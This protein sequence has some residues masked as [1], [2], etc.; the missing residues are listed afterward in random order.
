MATL[1]TLP[2]EI[3]S[4]IASHL[5]RPR[6]LLYLS[7]CC[8]R[9]FEF[10]KLDGW[11]AILKGRFGLGGLDLD[12]RRS[13]HG[14]STLYRNWERKG[15]VARYLE[16]SIAVTSINSW[17]PRR[18]KGPQGQTMGYQPSIDSYEDLYGAWTQRRE[19]LAWSAG[20]Q[21]VMRV[22]ETGSDIEKIR[23]AEEGMNHGPNQTW[24]YDSFR[25][26][27]SWFTYKIPDSFEGRD[28][29]TSLK[30]LR[31]HQRDLMNEDVVFGTASGRLSLL[32]MNP[33]RSETHEQTYATDGR[34]VGSLSISSS[35]SPLLAATLGDSSLALY[36]IDRE[37]P[38]DAAIE[39]FG[40]IVSLLPGART[41]RIW[42]SNFLAHDK[43]VLGAGPSPEPI[44]VY[45]IGPDGL[46]SHPLR[47]F[48]LDPN[49]WQD[50]K[51]DTSS[52]RSTSVYPTLPVP[53]TAKGGSDAGNTFL[54]GGY[55]G[56]IRLHDMRSPRGF[57]TLFWDAT[58]DSS[59]Y[60]LAAQ[61]LE[62]VVAG[63]SM[64]S[65]IK[66]FDLRFSGSNVYHTVARKPVR[67]SNTNGKDIAINKTVHEAKSNV[68]TVSGGW[69]LYLNPRIP[70][71]REAY[72]DDYWRGRDDSPVYRLS[73]PSPTSQNLYVGLEGAVQSLTFHSIADEHPDPMLSQSVVRFANSGHIDAQSSYNPCGDVLN[74]GM[75]EQGTEAGIGM[76]LFVQGG[77][78]TE[79][80]KNQARKDA[81]ESGGLD[82]RWKDLRDEGDRWVR[83]A[84]PQEP[85][86][87]R[88]RGRGGRG[89]ARGG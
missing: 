49:H 51:I 68:S 58:N 81:A 59:V 84:I 63:V 33:D 89:R 2:N 6:D 55:D 86:R 29:I 3:L 79:A 24:A 13:V 7:L 25:H 4:L 23:K 46:V 88:G 61:G 85:R 52:Q 19:V 32:S 47:S 67:G 71:K 18:W 76:Q 54:S 8:R 41:G 28:D 17:Q 74:L 26:L 12:A 45:K 34:A 42:S 44:Q 70:P 48:N 14:L 35:S 65:M 72:R 10:A 77:V 62:R 16:P 40:Q 1:S 30:L 56:I 69:N 31:P 5:E 39:P 20:T 73:I 75:Y 36:S 11:K 83:G 82:E 38:P 9:L 78:A 64:H 53:G 60:S 37:V 22:R 15:F 87:G 57:E 21:I 50:S 27:N 66:V 80:V 43:V